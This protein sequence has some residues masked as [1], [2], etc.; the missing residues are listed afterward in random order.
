[1]KYKTSALIGLFCSRSIAIDSVGYISTNLLP[2][3][4]DDP[5]TENMIAFLL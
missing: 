2:I 1:M 3:K 5:Y 4:P